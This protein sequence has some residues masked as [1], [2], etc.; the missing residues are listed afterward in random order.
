MNI[1]A[2]ENLEPGFVLA[3]AAIVFL[4]QAGFCLLES[5]MVR[6][7]NSINV[8]VKNVLDCSVAMLLFV[9]CG[10]SIMFGAS[11]LGLIGD[12]RSIVDF[13]DPKMVSFLLF[14]LV[15]CSAATTIV[16]GAV[17]ERVRVTTYLAI[18]LVVSG[19]VYPLYGHWVWGG[20]LPGTEA[21]WLARLGFVDWAGA[22]VVHVVG[23]FA[24]LAAAQVV[25]RRTNIPNAG[26]TGGSSLTLAIL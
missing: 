16:S 18:V 23:G 22:A 1:T 21:G 20:T 10:F 7:K 2:P 13:S 26:L 4:M 25:G 24:A 9:S 8:A 15:F 14:Q 19:F 17:A 12:P 6:A 11:Y 5:G 3:C